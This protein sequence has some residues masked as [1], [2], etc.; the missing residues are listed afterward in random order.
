M[1]R[2]AQHGTRAF[3]LA[4]ADK[5][6]VD[7]ISGAFLLLLCVAAVMKGS[8]WPLRATTLRAQQHLHPRMRADARPLA[9]ELRCLACGKALGDRSKL[10]QH[11]HDAHGGVNAPPG[12]PTM[13][14][15]TAGGGSGSNSAMFSLGDLLSARPQ[16]GAAPARTAAPPSPQ[17]EAAPRPRGV[18]GTLKV[19]SLLPSQATYAGCE[20]AWWIA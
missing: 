19:S 16:R 11:L 15:A 20:S 9:G 13:A 14:S 6:R 7:A 8:T 18:R 3:L 17:R 12:Q 10:A 2:Q 5:S 4:E 1:N